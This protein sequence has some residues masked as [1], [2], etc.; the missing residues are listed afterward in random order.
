M[1]VGDNSDRPRLIYLPPNARV[2]DGDRVVTSG[3]GG[4]FPPGL[5]VGTVAA[6]EGDLIRIDPLVNWDRIEFVRVIDLDP[7]GIVGGRRRTRT[8]Q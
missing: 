4:V 5:A 8:G 6:L 1:L 3:D 2:V 7:A